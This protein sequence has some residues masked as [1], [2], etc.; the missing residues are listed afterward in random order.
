[1]SKPILCMDF[2]GVIHSYTSGWV[3]ATFIP[4]PPVPGAIPFLHSAISHFDVCIFS[5]RSK[6]EGGIQAMS[7]WLEYW[8]RKQ[9]GWSVEWQNYVI[10]ELCLPYCNKRGDRMPPWPVS[11][12]AAFLTI[13]D[14]GWQ[15][16][17]TWPS[18]EQLLA[19]KP[20]NKQ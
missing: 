10:N 15:F 20:W 17:G 7:T 9:E 2:D 19:F 5:S 8:T 4:D 16:D 12:P 3:T 14:R 13:D 18:M 1:M 11:K 6:E